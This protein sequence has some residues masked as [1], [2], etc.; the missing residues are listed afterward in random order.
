MLTNRSGFSFFGHVIDPV[1]LKLFKSEPAT[2]VTGVALVTSSNLSAQRAGVRRYNTPEWRFHSAVEY[3]GTGGVAFKPRCLTMWKCFEGIFARRASRPPVLTP[4]GEGASAE[5]AVS[6]GTSSIVTEQATA[7]GSKRC[8]G[9]CRVE[10]LGQTGFASAAMDSSSA[11]PGSAENTCLK[12]SSI[13][14]Q[15]SCWM[16]GSLL[17]PS[18]QRMPVLAATAVRLCQW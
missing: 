15:M 13:P 14:T 9:A 6:T 10:T 8:T 5:A 1:W 18:Q 11:M 12:S 7:A 3:R 16:S 17:L 4:P 2:I